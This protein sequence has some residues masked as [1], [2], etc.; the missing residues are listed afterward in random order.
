M[1]TGSHVFNP[2][3]QIDFDLPRAGHVTL[4]IYNLTGQVIRTLVDE[5]RVAGRYA[6]TWDGKNEQGQ[7]VASGVYVYRLTSGDFTAIKKMVLMK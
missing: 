3:T 4:V 2:E 1:G 6:V 5:E 7:V